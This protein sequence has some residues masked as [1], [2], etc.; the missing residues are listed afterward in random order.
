MEWGT[1]GPASHL[2]L[3]EVFTV[4]SDAG[5]GHSMPGFCLRQTC[6]ET[7]QAVRVAPMQPC[8]GA[9]VVRIYAL[10]IASLC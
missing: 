8:K 5:A 6:S 7:A 2:L 10:S 9:W 1:A 3:A 4:V